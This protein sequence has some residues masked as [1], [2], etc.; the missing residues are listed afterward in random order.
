MLSEGTGPSCL[1]GR[2]P[3]ANWPERASRIEAEGAWQRR[4]GVMRALAR[5]AGRGRPGRTAHDKGNAM[6]GSKNRGRDSDAF[7]TEVNARLS[8]AAAAGATVELILVVKG[9]VRPVHGRHRERWRVRTGLGHVVTFRPEFVVAFNG[10]S[11]LEP[12]RPSPRSRTAPVD[13]R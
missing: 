8:E 2:P 6:R 5:H 4:P 9:R 3:E 1:V 11:H 7:I 13:S 10:G 12:G